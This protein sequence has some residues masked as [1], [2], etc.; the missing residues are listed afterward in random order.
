ML[1]AF[2]VAFAVVLVTAV[3]AAVVAAL[4]VVVVVVAVVVV[5]VVAVVTLHAAV[6]RADALLQRRHANV[7][8]DRAQ[9]TY[10][11]TVP[12]TPSPPSPIV[13]HGP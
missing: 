11:R 6:V 7:V 4:V 9:S 3:V 5:A 13:S 12:L 8:C 2:A 10:R 1:V